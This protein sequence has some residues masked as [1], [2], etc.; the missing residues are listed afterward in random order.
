MRRSS[1]TS[2]SSGRQSTMVLRVQD[3]NKM[4][5]QTPQTKDRGTFGKL[6]MSKTTSATSERKVSFFGKRASGAGGSRNSQ[7]GMFGTEKIKDPRPLHD[8]AFIQQCIKQLCEFLVENGYA[9]NVT[10][11]SLQSPSVKDFIKIFTF[12]Y[13]FLC[14]SYELPDSKFEEEIPRVF[15]ELGYPFPLSKSSMYTVGAPHTWP[16][17]VAALIW[18]TD[19][20][21]L[22][23]AMRENPS[24]FD[25]GQNWGGETDDGI[26]HNKLFMDYV[27]KC[28]EHFM[29]GGDTYEELDAEVQSKLKDLFNVDE[30]K[31]EGLAAENK[32]LHEEIARLEKERESEPDRLVSLRKLRS[33]F[34]ADVQKYQAYL[35]NLESHTTILDQKMKSVNEEVETTEMEV[36]A[37]KQE[38]ARLQHIF[39][40]Q[41]YSVAD[42]E[43]INHERNELQ[44]TINKLTKELEAEE[45]QLWNEE[46]KYA[47]NKE[48]I[49][50]Q[51]AE[52]HK[53]AR[54]LKLIPISAENSKGHDF[55]IHFNPE[56]GPNCLVKY[57]T[58]IKAPLMEI[59]NQ[60]EEEIRKATQRK[61][62]LED[63]LEQVNAMVAEKKSSVKT[64]KEEAEKLDDLYHQ[65]LKEAEEEEQKCAN[66]L[67]LLEKHKQL[68]ESG[69]NE[70]LSEATNELH[71]IQRQYQIVMQ[72]TTEESRKAG[73]NL[74]RLLEVIT[75][76]VVSIEKYLDEQN[77]KIDRD[78]EEFMSEDLLST[79][80]GI[81]DSYKKKAE[82]I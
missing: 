57:R 33:S 74:N 63:T 46:L 62:S 18:L 55:E 5:L 61:M 40:N 25:D 29:K 80:T 79:L 32:R 31:I 65:K 3:S 51:L 38:N 12:I 6:S 2:G 28:Y 39:D 60:T 1:T 69:V 45:H 52:Y 48:A 10:I 49:E 30:F 23:A 24:S 56:A 9:H 8:K 34:Q 67:E 73:D 82:S 20:F 17:I 13:G 77:S 43:R 59:V 71:D 11:K 70:G 26:V 7:Y 35:A 47:R 44:Q 14:P 21:K 16:Q 66:E 37:M 41:K 50:T 75:T 64:L 19:C 27:V 68:L 78:Y 53:L 54:K 22:Y 36:E 4:G 72:T 76:H 15:K 81:L 42:I 58:Q